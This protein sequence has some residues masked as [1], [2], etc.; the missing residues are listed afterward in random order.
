MKRCLVVA[1]ISYG[2][3]LGWLLSRGL[4]LPFTVA[5]LPFLILVTFP[6]AYL[7]F[8]VSTA[9]RESE[10]DRIDF[11]QVA[12]S[13]LAGFGVIGLQWLFLIPWI[14]LAAFVLSA[15]DLLRRARHLLL[16]SAQAIVVLAFGYGAIWNLNY[17]LLDLVHSR[18]HDL[19]IMNLDLELY[20]VFSSGK[21]AVDGLFPIVR[22]QELFLLLENSYPCLFLQI[23]V[24]LLLLLENGGP[25]RSFL[26]DVFGCYLFGLIV[27]VLYPVVGP[28][29]AFPE[30]FSVDFHGTL[31]YVLMQGMHNEYLAV[32]SGKPLTGYGYF[33]A[34]PSLHVSMALLFQLYL[35]RFRALFWCFLPVN[36]LMSISTFLLGYH[37]IVDFPTGL[38]VVPLVM[39]I[40]AWIQARFPARLICEQGVNG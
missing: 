29:I 18:L 26:V 22:S 11:R 5:F 37:Y 27:F 3:T 30:S 35:W 13:C 40:R 20:G 21:L 19:E 2:I 7:V 12:M 38:M 14:G 34:I 8:R 28:C 10:Y 31:T 24:I 15:W 33:I 16:P 39:G 23:V 6:S 4:S 32:L 17:S 25:F 9:L 36:I 1:A